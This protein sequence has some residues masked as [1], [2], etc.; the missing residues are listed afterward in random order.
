MQVFFL[1]DCIFTV[2][3]LKYFNLAQTHKF[4]LLSFE[5]DL[6][7]L[8]VLLSRILFLEQTIGEPGQ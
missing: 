6:D 8:F 7:G 5:R 2:N 3:Q 1:R 4:F